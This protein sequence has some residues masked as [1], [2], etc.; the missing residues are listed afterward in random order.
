MDPRLGS[1]LMVICHWL[2]ATL[3]HATRKLWDWPKLSK[4]TKSVALTDLGSLD[5]PVALIVDEEGRLMPISTLLVALG[6]PVIWA[7][8]MVS[9]LTKDV[10]L[11]GRLPSWSSGHPCR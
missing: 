5:S 6:C 7:M 3:V 4:T 9:K 2:L 8:L 1:V 10:L 11:V